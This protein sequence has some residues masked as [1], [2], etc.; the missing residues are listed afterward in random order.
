MN[1]QRTISLGEATCSERDMVRFLKQPVIMGFGIL[2]FF[3]KKSVHFFCYQ[4]REFRII[5]L[6]KELRC[7]KII[8]IQNC[9][10]LSSFILSVGFLNKKIILIFKKLSPNLVSVFFFFSE[11]FNSKTVFPK[12]ILFFKQPYHRILCQYFYIA[13]F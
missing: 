11:Q 1:L 3:R 2:F 8:F 5:L 6:R 7:F 9:V 4:T 10:N 12:I 13:T